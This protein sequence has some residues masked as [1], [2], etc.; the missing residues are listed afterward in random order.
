[1][2]QKRKKKT[3]AVKLHLLVR[4]AYSNRLRFIVLKSLLLQITYQ[5]RSHFC[6]PRTCEIRGLGGRS[7][8]MPPSSN[9]DHSWMHFYTISHSHVVAVQSVCQ[10]YTLGEKCGICSTVIDFLLSGRRDLIKLS[11]VWASGA[12][13]V[14]WSSRGRIVNDRGRVSQQDL[15]SSQLSAPSS[16]RS[17]CR[18]EATK[19]AE[20]SA[21][22]F[23]LLSR[24]SN[25]RQWFRR[26]TTARVD[27][28]IRL[29]SLFQSDFGEFCSIL[30]WSSLRSSSIFRFL[31]F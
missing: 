15:R 20:L 8:S 2:D 16:R 7:L 28:G 19:T 23:V 26:R 18:S 10:S 30:D 14:D 31:G 3:A 24:L 6:S 12:S 9:P 4:V 1:M 27:T 17:S 13:E 22:V 21:S 25:L 5:V 29:P 11:A